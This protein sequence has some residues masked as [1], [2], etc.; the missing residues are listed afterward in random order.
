MDVPQALQTIGLNEKETATYL[1]CLE[2]GQ[3]GVAR[4][5]RKANIKR[6][7]AYLVLESLQKR[8]LIHSVV[9]GKRTL[10]GAEEPTKLLGIIAEKDRALR[11]ILP[12]L[13]AINNRKVEKPGIRFYE[14]K[15]GVLRIYEEIFR[16]KEIRL[17]GSLNI[18]PKEFH[19][20]LESFVEKQKKER[21]KIFDLLT[22]TPADR[23]YARRV[24]RSGYEIRFFPKDLYIGT[25]SAVF[26]NKF[27]FMAFAPEP[28]GF[29]VEGEEMTKS[30]R[31]LWELAWRGAVPYKK[32]E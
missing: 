16:G 31:S 11:T 30:F 26:D 8:G 28:H 3:D 17:W 25:D 22:D 9:K 24:A 4:I 2:L 10:Y 7:T 18:L 29:I 15:A 19:P 23:E 5:A 14:G 12:Y 32:S 1:A 27:A 21:P 20:I 6:P 13:E